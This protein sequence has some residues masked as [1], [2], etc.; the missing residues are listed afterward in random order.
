MDA[1]EGRTGGGVWVGADAAGL[2]CG[3][4][5]RVPAWCPRVEVRGGPGGTRVYLD[6]AEAVPVAPDEAPTLP[7]IGRPAPNPPLPPAVPEDEADVFGWVLARLGGE[8]DDDGP[9]TTP[10]VRPEAS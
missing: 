1:G 3:R 7:A 4:V 6:G 9:P 5:V 2:A 8:A 10:T